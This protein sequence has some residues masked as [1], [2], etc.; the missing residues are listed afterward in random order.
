MGAGTWL[1]A[2]PP[3][4]CVTLLRAAFGSAEVG[5]RAGLAL[6]ACLGGN[7]ALYSRNYMSPL[8]PGGNLFLYSHNYM[9][10]LS[11]GLSN[12]E[13]SW[14]EGCP[15]AHTLSMRLLTLPQRAWTV[16]W[17]LTVSQPPSPPV[18]LSFHSPELFLL[19]SCPV[20]ATGCDSPPS[21]P[22]KGPSIRSGASLL[23]LQENI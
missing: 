15:S 5:A 2:R 12:T 8:S 18:S 21:L 20:R 14:Q 11:P 6:P 4:A 17:P 13:Q 22:T 10:L 19:S 9:S 1:L 3:D 23:A 16:L 7:L